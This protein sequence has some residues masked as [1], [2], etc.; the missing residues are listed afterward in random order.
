MTRD[1][2]R[3][4]GA[5]ADQNGKSTT[6]EEGDVDRD[7]ENATGGSSNDILRAMAANS[8]VNLLR[9]LDGDDTLRA[10]EGTA[11]VDSLICGTGT[12][13]RV[14]KDPSD[15]QVGCEVALP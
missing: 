10:R 13:D 2:K 12:A 4:D 8:V 7:V 9:G 1:R 15:T 6:A 11:T 14:A 3:N 5:D